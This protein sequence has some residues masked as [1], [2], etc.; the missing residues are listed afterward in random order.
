MNDPIEIAVNVNRVAHVV[1][2]EFKI[3]VAIVLVDIFGRPGDQ[4]VDC[5]N[6]VSIAQKTIH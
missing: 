4:I 6:F 3:R 5:H 2:H 1:L